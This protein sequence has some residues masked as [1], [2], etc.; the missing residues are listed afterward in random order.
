MKNTKTVFAIGLLLLG[1]T[2]TRIDEAGE[3]PR[4]LKV[5][6]VAGGVCHDFDALVPHLTSSL[7]PLLNAT[8][9]VKLDLEIWKD[10]QFADAYDAVVYQF[11]RDEAEGALIDHALQAT[12]S[13]KPTVIIHGVVHSFRNS[14]RVGE[15]EKFCGMRSKVH[16]PFQS[17]QTIKLDLAHPITKAWPENW[18]TSGDEL[19]QTIEFLAGSHPLLKVKSPQDGREH[20]VSWTSSYGKGRVFTTTLG[21]D[22]KTASMPSYHRLLS[23]GLLWACGKLGDDGKP[24]TGYGALESNEKK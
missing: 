5:L 1:C 16:D 9:D 12:R 15:W 11:C 8:F 14:D 18:T 19:Y 23:D 2:T 3:R 4:P 21:H 6:W 22:L 13:G 7:R 24:T 20:I 10:E 17:F